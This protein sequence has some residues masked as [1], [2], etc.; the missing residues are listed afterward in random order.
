MLN[1]LD[2]ELC[3]FD[4]NYTLPEIVSINILQMNDIYEINSVE[5]GLHG[6]LAR[7]A[8]LKQQLCQLN[9]NT[10]TILSGD[11]LSPSALG[12]AKID[13]MPLA[14]KQM[15]AV[16]N[17]VGVNYATFGNHEF[18]I[19]E[20]LFDQRLKESCFTWFSG[21]ISDR[22]G[23]PFEKVPRF[24]TFDVKNN[25]GTIARVGLIGITTTLNKSNYVRYTD[26]ITTGNQQA[27]FLRDKVDILIAV[28]HLSLEEDCKL[29]SVTPEIDII[30]GG[31]DH[32]VINKQN[33]N[34]AP[35]FKSD[36]N[37]RSIYVHQLVYNTIKK[38]L[39]INSCLVPITR[40]I[41][42]NIDT[43]KV[44]K[45]WLERG[46]EAFIANG[47]NPEEKIVKLP[48][49]LNGLEATVRKKPTI[50]TKLI[51]RSMLQETGG[52]D[53][54]VFNSGLIRIDRVIP[55]GWITQYDVVSILPYEGDN[56][57]LVEVTGNI[58]SE[59]LTKGEDNKG[60]GAYLQ[61][62]HVIWHPKAQTWLIN[63]QILDPEKKYRIAVNKF[64][65]SGKEKG[66]NFFDLENPEVEIIIEKRDMRFALI[67]QLALL[68]P[69]IETTDITEFWA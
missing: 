59:V 46:Y 37:G 4:G 31:H 22:N 25:Y 55:P 24:I 57:L 63:G 9:P 40:E 6:G 62:C 27:K 12:F 26:P 50:L 7:I 49:S 51:A 44:V 29:A 16:L 61:T 69:I 10:Y 14:G 53:L 15:V 48:I 67:E 21:N 54:A 30:V 3:S 20:S 2:R 60:T 36:V 34:F 58:L 39:E 45:K 38:T 13:G 19:P 28:T 5:G 32:K 64:L 68:R 65:I 35:I 17:S 66:L 18:D 56:C 52:A 23:Q 8:T 47:F 42:E 43:E 1:K 41:P 11:F 33:D